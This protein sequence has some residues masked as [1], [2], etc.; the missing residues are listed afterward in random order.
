M[1]KKVLVFISFLF[2]FFTV[3]GAAEAAT[4]YFSPSSGSF[5]VSQ[6]FQV[7]VFVSGE[8]QAVN[9]YSGVVSF[10]RDKLLVASVATAGSIVNYWVTEPSFSNSTGRVSFEG[11][12]LNPGFQ[13]SAGRII[14]ITFKG[15]KGGIAPLEWQESSVLAADGFGTNVLRSVSGAQFSIAVAPPLTPAPPLKEPEEKEAEKIEIPKPE[16]EPA[17]LEVKEVKEEPLSPF[18]K[19]GTI[20]IS[21][22]TIMST[23]V[24][25]SVVAIGIVFYA[26]YRINIWRKRMR[27]ETKEVAQS[28]LSAFKALREE[29]AEQIELLDGKPGLNRDERRVRDKLKEAL[30]VSEEFIGKEI[31]DIEKSL[32]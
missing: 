2:V 5:N 8:G 14:T 7:G 20:A 29:V 12:T 26:W 21:Y 13:G 28:V 4:L 18:V 30:S 9:G 3:W 17:P 32:E 27:A 6:T 11:V 24:V 31:K 15:S 16:P 22:L 23:L 25:L 1:E 19:F 10:P